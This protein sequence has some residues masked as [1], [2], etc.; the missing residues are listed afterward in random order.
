MAAPATSFHVSFVLGFASSRRKARETISDKLEGATRANDR[1]LVFEN[2]YPLPNRAGGN[3]T[4]RDLPFPFIILLR[5]SFYCLS[6]YT[7][8]LL[9]HSHPPFAISRRGSGDKAGASFAGRS[10]PFNFGSSLPN[11]HCLGGQ[12]VC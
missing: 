11:L 7:H 4:F 6:D 2:M 3:S 9:L 1:Q 8:T 10:M 12:F 5:A